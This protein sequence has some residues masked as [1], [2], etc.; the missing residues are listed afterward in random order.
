M[1]RMLKFLHTMGA[2]GPFGA[3]TC[4]LVLLAFTPQPTSLS[5]YA[6]DARGDGRPPAG[7][8]SCPRSG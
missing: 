5:E 6:L 2:I 1:R 4:L 7:W 8:I 3:M